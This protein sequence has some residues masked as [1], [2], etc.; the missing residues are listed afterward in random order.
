VSSA[1]SRRL[2]CY[3]L[4]AMASVPVWLVRYVPVQDLPFHA[5][6]IRILASFH[7]PAYRF[8]DDFVLTL[9]RT[10]YVL[11]HLTGAALARFAGPLAANAM[12]MSAYLSGTVLALHSL[13][14]ALG[15]D[16]RLCL[17]VIPLLVNVPFMLGLLPFMLGVPIMLA[18][19]AAAVRYVRAPTPGRGALVA[20][21]TLALFYSHVVPF[22]LFGIAYATLFPWTRPRAWMTALAPWTPVVP[23]A[24]WWVLFTNAGRVSR[25]VLVDL[26]G[27]VHKAL[28]PSLTDFCRVVTGVFT[29]ASDERVFVATLIVALGAV[30]LSASPHNRAAGELRAY[31]LLPAACLVCYLTLAEAHDYVF[32]I[33]QRFPVLVLMTAIPLLSMPSGWKGHVVTVAAG[34]IA[35]IS[36]VNA[37]SHFQR[38]ERQEVG[39]FESAIAEMAPNRRVCA[40]IYDPASRIIHNAAFLHFGS[41]YQVRKGGVVMFTYAGYPH[42]PV[43]FAAGRYPPPGGAA[44]LRWEWTPR[45]VPM[46]EIYPY[47]DY[48]LTRGIGFR[49]PAGTYRETWHDDHWAVWSRL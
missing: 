28:L 26:T 22:L 35:L 45:T 15:R 8:G 37:G 16:E 41:Y 24:L 29:D 39:G 4:A 14:R 12:L 18:A 21:L 6:T 19:T 17:F 49:P 46:K 1:L 44:R 34:A 42:W 5:A 2:P 36:I 47:Y 23:V 3:I 32:F 48:V 33:A 30:V 13:L 7:D 31:A 43:D 9:T 20:V 40:L 38:F 25:S 27:G 10:Q 11:Y